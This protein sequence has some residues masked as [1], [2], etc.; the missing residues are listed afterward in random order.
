MSR[1]S[2]TTSLVPAITP[3]SMPQAVWNIIGTVTAIRRAASLVSRLVLRRRIP[4]TL[5]V[6]KGVGGHRKLA[7]LRNED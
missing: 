3:S 1:L 4:L 2:K 6:E 5:V 7:P